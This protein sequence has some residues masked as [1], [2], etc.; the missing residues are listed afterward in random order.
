MT[1]RNKRGPVMYLTVPRYAEVG[2][3]NGKESIEWLATF[4]APH[5]ARAK[6][7]WVMCGTPD[8]ATLAGRIA[9]LAASCTANGDW[10]ES[11][12]LRVELNGGRWSLM[13]DRKLQQLL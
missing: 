5:Y 2:E 7:E 11:G 10:M 3:L 13:V 9:Q 8:A 12:G 1:G 6:W 4:L